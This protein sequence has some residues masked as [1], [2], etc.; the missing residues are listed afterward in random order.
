MVLNG[1]ATIRLVFLALIILSLTFNAFA[2]VVANYRDE[3]IY[4]E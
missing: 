3:S 2:Y 4:S 1:K